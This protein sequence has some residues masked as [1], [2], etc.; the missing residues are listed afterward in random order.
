MGRP[1]S[2]LRE[3]GDADK[4]KMYTGKEQFIEDEDF[5]GYMQRLK[6]N[7][8]DLAA[9]VNTPEFDRDVRVFNALRESNPGDLELNIPFRTIR[10]SAEGLGGAP[11]AAIERRGPRGEFVDTRSNTVLTPTGRYTNTGI[12]IVSQ[13]SVQAYGNCSIKEYI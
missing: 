6:E 4:R 2:V 9:T 7:K 3:A 11:T 5:K 1:F 12:A 10:D 13:P 8:P